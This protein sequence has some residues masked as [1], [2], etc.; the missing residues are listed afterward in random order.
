MP[1]TT[2]KLNWKDIL[3]IA[4]EIV[5]SYDTPVTLRQL[6]YRLVATGSIPNTVAAYKMLSRTT[7]E[8][9]RQGWF[10]PL[11]DRTRLVHQPLSFSSPAQATDYL[12]AIYRR[13]RTQGQ[14]YNIFI[15]VEKA[16]ILEQL[17]SWF[18]P[19]GVPILALGGYASQSFCDEVLAHIQADGRPAVLIYAG[20]FDPSGLDIERDFLQR[21]P[22]FD[23]SIRVALS[24]QQVLQYDLPP[25]PGK[26]TDPRAASFSRRH[27]KLVQVELDAL[28]PDILRQLYQAAFFDWWDNAA[29]ES[30]LAQE[31]VDRQLL[32]RLS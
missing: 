3:H 20:D 26:H 32:A 24:W 13:D 22:Y 14:R 4:A 17:Y 8:A 29:Y 2:A 19:Y 1:R 7:A 30:V 15:G 27:G 21:T 9:R 18:S 31:K 23:Y 11:I 28:P 10:P 16:G 6:F 25:Q 5:E 12:H